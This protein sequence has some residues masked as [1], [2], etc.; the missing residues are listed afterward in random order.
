MCIIFSKQQ[1]RA[2][3]KK[4]LERLRGF[5]NALNNV[6]QRPQQQHLQLTLLDKRRQP[7]QQ[8]VLQHHQGP[9]QVQRHH[10]MTVPSTITQASANTP[11]NR[12]RQPVTIHGGNVKS[13]PGRLGGVVFNRRDSIS[14]PPSPTR[15]M[16]IK[17]ETLVSSGTG[18]PIGEIIK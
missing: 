15:S 4:C 14:L 11:S 7:S 6:S 8:S 9:T 2:V 16:L 17:K 1:R 3:E 5:S 13:T 10:L 12:I 18:D